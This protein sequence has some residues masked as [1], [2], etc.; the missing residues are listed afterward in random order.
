MIVGEEATIKDETSNQ[1]E[2][3]KSNKPQASK[4]NMIGV[5]NISLERLA[6]ISSFLTKDQQDILAKEIAQRLTNCVDSFDAHGSTVYLESDN[7]AVLLAIDSRRKA[8]EYGQ[9]IL[10]SLKQH[11]I[12]GDR[13]IYLYPCIGISFCPSDSIEIEELLQQGV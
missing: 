12:V 3:V 13:E 10:N 5:F 11:F 9:S 1:S 7:F 4:P 8:S 6:K 2:L